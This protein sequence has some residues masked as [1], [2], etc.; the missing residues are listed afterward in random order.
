MKRPRLNALLVTSCLVVLASVSCVARHEVVKSDAAPK[1]EA[2]KFLPAPTADSRVA[3]P[4]DL[5]ELEPP[6]IPA[7]RMPLGRVGPP[8]FFPPLGIYP[9]D[10]PPYPFI[11]PVAYRTAQPEPGQPPFPRPAGV[12][13]RTVTTT[14]EAT[15][16]VKPDEAVISVGIQ[17]NDAELLRARTEVDDRAARMLQAIRA[18]GILAD[19]VQTAHLSVSMQY[20]DWQKRTGQEFVVSRQ[21]T[22][23]LKDLSKLAT[24]LDAALSN[25]AN[26]LNGVELQ[27]SELRKHKDEARKLAARA[28]KEKASLLATELGARA[29]QILTINEEQSQIPIP[30]Q[31][32]N[33]AM[34]S[35]VAGGVESSDSIPTGQIAIKASVTTTFQLE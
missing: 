22:V 18:A 4:L 28:A 19:D 29:G 33:V 16:Y 6:S 9:V 2:L 20:Q 26:L 35:Q 3:V 14:G 5:Q 10:P 13:V 25:G 34:R 31:L 15:V 30:F 8:E 11:T 21:Y 32:G 12:P 24:T 23:K 27:S 17:V 7:P 1:Q